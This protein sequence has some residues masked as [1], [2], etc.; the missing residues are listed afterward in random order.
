MRTVGL[1]DIFASIGPTYPL[2]QKYGLTYEGV[3]ETVRRLVRGG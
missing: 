3:A 1:N 2:M